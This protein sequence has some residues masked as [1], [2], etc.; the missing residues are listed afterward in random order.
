VVVNIRKSD[1]GALNRIQ[2]SQFLV[3]ADLV[4]E[5]DHQAIDTQM[6]YLEVHLLM[7]TD[8][9]GLQS[10]VSKHLQPSSTCHWILFAKDPL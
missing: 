2:D 6:V 3:F 10:L 7:P 1:R 8:N 9:P 5:M 4:C